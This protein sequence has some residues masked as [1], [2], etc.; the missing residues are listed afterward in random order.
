VVKIVTT[1]VGSYPQPDWLVDKAKFASNAVPRVRRREIWRPPEALLD[2]AQD[3]A[4]RVAVRDME[5]AGIDLVTDGE[6]RRESYFNQFANTLDG[7]DP[8]R[9]GVAIARTGR[10]T[11]VPR[12]IGPIRRAR[13]VLAREMRFLRGIPTARSR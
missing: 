1:V 4:V 7:L 12:V 8:E 10:P 9:P 2:E 6:Q 5:G 11:P 13:S 3:N